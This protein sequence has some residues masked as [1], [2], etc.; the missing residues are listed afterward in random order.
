MFLAAES[1][2]VY[3]QNAFEDKLTQDSYFVKTL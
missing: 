2:I 3:L 1:Y